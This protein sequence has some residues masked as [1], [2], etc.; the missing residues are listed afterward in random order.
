MYNGVNAQ[1]RVLI[2]KDIMGHY[3]SAVDIPYINLYSETDD[4]EVACCIEV[5]L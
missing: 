4:D 1:Y 3:I 2:Y 5:V